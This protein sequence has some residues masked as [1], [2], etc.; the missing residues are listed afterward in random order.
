MGG[1]SIADRYTVVGGLASAVAQHARSYGIDINPICAALELEPALFQSLTARISLDRL[2][3]L[4]EACAVLANDDA[5]GLKCAQ[6]FN[7]GATGP[8]GYGLI[9]APT[10]RDFLAFLEA[11]AQYATHTNYIRGHYEADSVRI[12]WSFAPL[13]V[14]R[15]Q[16]VD[17]SIALLLQ[18]LEA[19]VG[20]RI[21]LVALE[22]ERP[23]PRQ[24]PL[25]RDLLIKQLRF[26]CR[27]N[28]IIVPNALLDISNPRSDPRL[29]TLMDMQCKAMRP[30]TAFMNQDFVEQVRDYLALRISEPILSLKDI[31][32]YFGVS[33]RSFQRRLT[34]ND[35][36]LN[37][38]RDTVRRE[39]SL[40]LL[41]DSELPI[42]EISYRLGYSA[43]SAF[44]RSVT[45][46][47]GTTPTALRGSHGA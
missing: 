37:L 15:D 47:F 9:T 7:A 5:F 34:E 26:D 22:M 46:W 16:F 25:F 44:T 2:C 33:E 41:Q 10:V 11:H 30:D 19:I 40:Q 31:S 43:P 6:H 3:R 21:D 27:F 35:T 8:F 23:K 36:N 39:V 42:N 20:D 14:K 29:F 38:L 45:R 32:A 13:I 18:R 4:L 1:R 28:T 12:E 24:M 17:M